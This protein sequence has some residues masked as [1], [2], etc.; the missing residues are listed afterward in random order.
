MVIFRDANNTIK[1]D[2]FLHYKI[3]VDDTIGGIDFSCYDT[4]DNKC[5]IVYYLSDVDWVFEEIRF[6]IIKDI[7]DKIFDCIN[8]NND[9]IDLHKI[10]IDT[11]NKYDI[12]MKILY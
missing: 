2:D 9:V 8:E 5:E 10:I 6:D 12:D 3:E 4:K 1:L 7:N 11:F